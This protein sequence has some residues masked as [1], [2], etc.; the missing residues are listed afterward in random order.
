[1]SEPGNV[2]EMAP[3][4]S[5]EQLQGALRALG[6][7]GAAVILIGFVG[8]AAWATLAPLSGSI[9]ATGIVKV[10]SNRK[11]VQHRDGGIVSEILV[12]EG[13][14]VAQGQPLILLDD[15]RIDSSFDLLRSQLDAELIR[16]MRLSAER[17]YAAE[18]SPPPEV[19][20]RQSDARVAEMLRRE[21]GIFA[22]RRQALESQTSLTRREIEQ[23]DA[24]VD[25]RQHQD[26]SASAAIKLM[27]EEVAANEALLSGNF[28]NRTKV[29]TLQRA[30]AEYRMRQS[31]NLAELAKARQRK[32]QLELKIVSVRETYAT[33]S[34][35]ELRDTASKL[36]DIEER[37]RAARD[38]AERKI[39]TAPVAGR[40]VDLHVT[41]PG[42][43]IGPREPVLD[44]V[45][46][47]NLLIVEAHVPLDAISELRQGMRAEVRL[48]AYKQRTTPLV[49]GRV[50][51]VSADALSEKQGTA[52]HFVTYIELSKASLDAAGS[53]DLHPGMAAEVYIKTSERT[54]LDY[55]LEPIV[56]SIRRAFRDH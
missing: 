9:V 8:T 48:T 10:D 38:A 14:E 32:S 16:R 22:A 3:A 40:V 29:M 25:A 56:V 36:V 7:T 26:A 31:D 23:V 15:A 4:Q 50:T 1:M 30:A 27:D 6:V 24:E 41:T 21:R 11:T 2:P 53:L 44:I 28:I 43:P 33:E 49:E 34:N 5:S 52:P 18:W 35:S 37:L 17:D 12:H 13:Q 54:A 39:I 19:G 55:F 46:R 42:S 45:P 51:Y 47:D 20:T